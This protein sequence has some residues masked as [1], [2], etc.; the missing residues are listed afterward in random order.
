[1]INVKENFYKQIEL[2]LFGIVMIVAQHIKIVFII[3]P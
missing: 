2:I 3:F 1:M